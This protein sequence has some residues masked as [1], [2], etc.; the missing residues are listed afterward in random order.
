ME[1]LDEQQCQELLGSRNVGRVAF[2]VDAAP[3]IFPVNYVANG[4][5]VVFR[6]AGDTRLHRSVKQRVAFEVDDW[7]ESA[8]LAWSVVIKGIAEEIT[9]GIDPV[10]TA[11][12]RTE[13]VPLAPGAREHWMAVYPSEITGRRF[14]R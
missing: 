8:G 1:V 11:L 12:L 9:Q 6:T 4:S 10:A 7:D 3:E 14:R 13:V 5:T 2:S